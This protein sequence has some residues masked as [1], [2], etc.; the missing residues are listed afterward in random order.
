MKVSGCHVANM[1][2]DLAA[3]SAPVHSQT[4]RQAAAGSH[5]DDDTSDDAGDG[6]RLTAVYKAAPPAAAAADEVVGMSP[7]SN[8]SR[9]SPVAS[10][11]RSPHAIGRHRQT[12]AVI[13]TLPDTVAGGGRQRVSFQVAEPRSQSSTCIAAGD[14]LPRRQTELTAADHHRTSSVDDMRTCRTP[15]RSPRPPR[16]DARATQPDQVAAQTYSHVN[17]SGDQTTTTMTFSLKKD[18]VD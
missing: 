17:G 18:S 4:V 14:V 1:H 10:T 2:G 9:A 13:H 12:L 6:A 15:S 16:R 5:S 11:G 7:V 8:S 3:C